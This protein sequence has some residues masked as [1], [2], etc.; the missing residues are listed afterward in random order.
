MKK[1][2]NILLIITIC[3]FCILIGIFLGRNLRR[4]Y[5]YLP[6]AV[7]QASTADPE[8]STAE[9]TTGK[10]NINTATQEQLMLLP[11]IGASLAQRIIEYRQENGPFRRPEDIKS[12]SG[13]GDRK[14]S[15]IE[16]YITVG[17]W[18]ENTGN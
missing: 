6:E 13:I 14:F 1:S 10:I 7:D 16:K 5:V 12:V 2:P 15:G 8:A 9:D 3:F 4:S 17:D 11:G 18:N